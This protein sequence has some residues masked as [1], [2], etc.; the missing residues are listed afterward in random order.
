[1]A[2]VRHAAFWCSVAAAAPIL[3]NILPEDDQERS[4]LPLMSDLQQCWDSLTEDEVQNNK[5]FPTTAEDFWKMYA[6]LE[7]P[8][9]KHQSIL[10]KQMPRN[11]LIT[12]FKGATNYHNRA[13]LLSISQKGSWAWLT[14]LP[15]TKEL[16]LNNW[17]FETAIAVHLGRHPRGKIPDLCACGMV[18]HPTHFFD[19]QLL[20]N[21]SVRIRHD[22]LKNLVGQLARE[23]GAGVKIEPSS[24]VAYNK[25][26]DGHIF[27]PD[28]Q[29][30]FDTSVINSTAASHQH[31]AQN[32]LSAA[33]KRER[34]K[35]RMYGLDAGLEGAK[36]SPAVMES[37]G[38][39]GKEF[40]KL[41]KYLERR[42]RNMG[43]PAMLAAPDSNAS[44]TEL[45]AVALR[46]GNAKIIWDGLR[47]AKMS[48]ER[49]LP[50]RRSD[51][52]RC[53]KNHLNPPERQVNSQVH[54]EVVI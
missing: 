6:P 42:R 7:Q 36:F 54:Y 27:F 24:L 5:Y 17:E 14:A 50:V 13:R 25:R 16:Q 10:C 29:I 51:R 31:A 46:K 22:R 35:V 33:K 52:N 15:N 38:A 41:I 37:H 44:A 2:K 45:M 9:A 40:L 32:P 28:D 21:N 3:V 4:A 43:M 23:A 39:F 20:R 19:C 30:M 48:R 18:N 49:R 12:M 8:I 11:C 34:G 47:D 53:L 26:P 1:M